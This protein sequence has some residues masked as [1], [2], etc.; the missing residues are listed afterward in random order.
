MQQLVKRGVM[1]S[2]M[3]LATSF[4][5]ISHAEQDSFQVGLH[6]L[7]PIT[8]TLQSSLNFPSVVAGQDNTVTTAVDSSDAVI[9]SATGEANASVI[10]SVVEDFVVMTTGEG[11]TE[12][13]RIIV[14]GFLTGGD[15]G[16]TGNGV[17]NTSGELSN[18]RIGA[19]AHV[20]ANDVPGYYSSSATFRLTYD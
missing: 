16:D 9:F 4:G 5:Q 6:L 8:L 19:T 7:S 1:F 2:V 12:P 17:F 13:E 20:Q 14:D 10:G 3:V 18:L 15:L 11:I